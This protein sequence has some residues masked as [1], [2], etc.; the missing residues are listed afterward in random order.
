MNSRAVRLITL[1]VAAMAMSGAFAQKKI[2]VPKDFTSIQ[3]AIDEA[4]ERDTVFVLNGVYKESI[5]LKDYVA[6]IGQEA[7][8]TVIRGNG[9]K[10]VVEGANYCVLKNFTIENGGTGIICKNTNPLIEHNIV[11]NNKKT[12]IHCLISLPEIK[13]NLI[14]SNKWSGIYCEL[15][16]NAQRTSIDHN[17]IA[18]NGYS[19]I[20]LANKSEVLI[21][22]DIFFGNK[23]YGIYVNEDS[24]RS[25]IVYNDFFKNRSPFN[26]YAV[27]NE[28]NISIDPLLNPGDYAF[29]N[30]RSQL[31]GL[32]KDGSD[33]GPL[34]E[35]AVEKT[36]KKSAEAIGALNKDSDGDGIPDIYDKCPQAPEDFDGFQDQDG[37]P[38]P[39]NDADGIPDSLDKCPN[40]PEDF[41]GYMDDDG[42]PDGGK[43]AIN[44]STPEKKPFSAASAAS[45]QNNPATPV[46]KK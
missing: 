10:P 25:R 8:K 5:V 32:G 1:F 30:G 22:D 36:D 2:I 21:R 43:P 45:G 7:E 18:D 15:I 14:Y 3:K 11:R 37:C 4:G 38:D 12:G 24:K 44:Q 39:D 6:V 13:N 41:N 28:T 29:F 46:Q 17:L 16:T 33:I 23:Q 31:K 27:I 40:A 42:C 19:G 34:G 35:A 9:S 26:P 20:M